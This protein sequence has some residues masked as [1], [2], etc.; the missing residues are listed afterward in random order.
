MKSSASIDPERS[1]AIT[2]SMPSTDIS[3]RLSMLCGLARATTM[4]ATAT[5]RKA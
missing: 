5:Q 1:M 3:C 4:A 2:M